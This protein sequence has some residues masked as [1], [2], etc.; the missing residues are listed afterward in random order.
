MIKDIIIIDDPFIGTKRLKDIPTGLIS[1]TDDLCGLYVEEFFIRLRDYMDWIQRGVSL[2]WIKGKTTGTKFMI[3][4]EHEKKTYGYNLVLDREGRVFNE[5]L[6]L[7]KKGGGEFKVLLELTNGMAIPKSIFWSVSSNIDGLLNMDLPEQPYGIPLMKECPSVAEFMQEILGNS[8]CLPKQCIWEK[9]WSLQEEQQKWIKG[10]LVTSGLSIGRIDQKWR[11][12]S[13]RNMEMDLKELGS[14]AQYLIETLPYFL[15]SLFS[16]TT[17]IDP[18]LTNHLHPLLEARLVD[19]LL[20]IGKET[21]TSYQVLVPWMVKTEGKG[22]KI[23][24]VNT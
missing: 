10:F 7:R 18:S 24:T 11:L 22:V 14:G 23:A 15:S 12:F 9:V 5:R 21:K 19:G 20:G 6:L 1:V 2:D 3:T 4:W 17:F 16:G 8:L 13:E